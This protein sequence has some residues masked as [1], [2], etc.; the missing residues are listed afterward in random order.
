MKSPNHDSHEFEEK[1]T[2]LLILNQAAIIVYAWICPLALCC[3]G[4]AEKCDFALIMSH[5]NVEKYAHPIQQPL[6]A[7]IPET[8]YRPLMDEVPI[9]AFPSHADFVAV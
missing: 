5:K 8:K 2:S 9:N 6:N 4:S 3:H 7:R 1:A